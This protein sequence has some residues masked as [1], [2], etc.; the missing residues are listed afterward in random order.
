MRIVLNAD[1]F[2]YSSE[3]VT[4]TIACFEQGLLTSASIQPGMPATRE[5]LEFAKT[6]PE[7]S[8]GV[9]LTFVGD[10][11][12][13]PLAAASDVQALVDEDGAF[14]STREIRILALLGRVPVTQIE[15]ELVAQLESVRAAGVQISHVDS[16]RHLHKFGPFR[17]ALRSVLP[18]FGI[19]RVR[20]VQDVYMRRP[21]LSPTFWVGAIWRKRLNRDFL[22]TDHFYMPTSAGDRDWGALAPRLERLRGSSIEVGVH[23]GHEEEWR[24]RE[25]A[26]LAP[27][28]AAARGAGH[29][30]VGWN[31]IGT[32]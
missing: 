25:R 26:A 19:R 28:V 18:R 6:R 23:P 29:N 16:H 17:S 32:D 20:T 21:L 3:T 27:F 7:L 4:A 8:F 13:R 1:D 11:Q 9:H 22:T 10:G 31:D 5:A 2:G 24:R 12:E 30:L 14:R 15:R